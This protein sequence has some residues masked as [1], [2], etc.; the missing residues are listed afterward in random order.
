MSAR[1]PHAFF[2]GLAAPAFFLLACG[3]L[4]FVPVSAAQSSITV[5]VTP[6][7]ASVQV[8]GGMQQFDARVITTGHK[9]SVRW[10]LSGAGC[11][12]STCGT[13]SETVSASGSAITYTAPVKLPSPPKVTLTA[14]SASDSSKRAHVIITLTGS[15]SAAAITTAKLTVPASATGKADTFARGK[16]SGN[17]D[18]SAAVSGD[19]GVYTLLLK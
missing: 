1:C 8:P 6:K 17:A 15:V 4:V 12:G 5:T 3:I 16:D 13:L 14:T 2:Q 7:T 10:T 9:R 18:S 19:R 11:G